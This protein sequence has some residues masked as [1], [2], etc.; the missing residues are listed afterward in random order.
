MPLKSRAARD[1]LCRE[2]AAHSAPDTSGHTPYATE[3]AFSGAG[4]GALRDED[5]PFRT[6]VM[7]GTMTLTT[8]QVLVIMRRVSRRTSLHCHCRGTTPTGFAQEYVPMRAAITVAH[9]RENSR[10]LR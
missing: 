6:S 3:T 5:A 9:R 2:R 10:S 4:H 7:L 1:I 8:D